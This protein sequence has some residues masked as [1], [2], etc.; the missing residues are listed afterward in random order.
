MKKCNNK[1]E[2]VAE[3]IPCYLSVLVEAAKKDLVQWD[4]AMQKQG[5]PVGCEMLIHKDFEIH[6]YMFVSMCSVGSV[7]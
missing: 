6:R 4:L 1:I 3:K 7:S 5:L 2:N